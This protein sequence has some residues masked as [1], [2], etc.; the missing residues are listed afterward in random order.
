MNHQDFQGEVHN[1]NSIESLVNQHTGL[2]T[3]TNKINGKVFSVPERHVIK[4]HK[5]NSRQ[6]TFQQYIMT[7]PQ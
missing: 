2:K 5:A 7:E 1:K 4:S 6:L 3:C